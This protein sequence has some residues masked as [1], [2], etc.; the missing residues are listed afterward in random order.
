MTVVRGRLLRKDVSPL[1]RWLNMRVRMSLSNA[2][3][4]RNFTRL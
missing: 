4:N 2:A 3:E 1:S